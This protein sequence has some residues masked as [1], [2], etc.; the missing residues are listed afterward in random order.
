[1][2]LH[3]DPQDDSDGHGDHPC[4][5]G[6]PVGHGRPGE[7]AGNPPDHEADGER[8]Q[9]AEEA[10]HPGILVMAATPDRDERDEHQEVGER[11]DPG[12]DS[13]FVHFAIVADLLGRRPIQASK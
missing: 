13:R 11:G 10:G 9:H 7:A 12:R 6:A 1:V 8:P 2:T 4:E 3:R 5:G